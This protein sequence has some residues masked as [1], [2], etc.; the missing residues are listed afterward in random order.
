MHPTKR[1]MNNVTITASS[2]AWPMTKNWE[3]VHHIVSTPQKVAPLTGEG[4]G[5]TR[6][7]DVGRSPDGSQMVCRNFLY[8]N[9]GI[10][11]ENLTG[12]SG[13]TNVD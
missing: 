6:Y 8:I 12:V 7:R 1:T 4:L 9:I 13:I 2:I 3:R 10:W 5:Y 11:V